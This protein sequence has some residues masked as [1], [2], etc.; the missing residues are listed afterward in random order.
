MESVIGRPA[1]AGGSTRIEVEETSQIG[2]ARRSASAMGH[3]QGLDEEAVGRLAIVTTEA[4]TNI[5]RHGGGGMIV[6]RALCHGGAAIEVLALDKG[7]G[8]LNID[9]AMVDGYSTGGTAGEGLGAMRRLSDVFAVHSQRGV[10]T[11]VLARVGQR[12]HPNIQPPRQAV[13]DDR[14][15]VVCVPMRG[16]MECG[17]R[18]E[19]VAAREG[20]TLMLV[21]GLGHGP[22][23]AAAAACAAQ[24]FH[25][26][27]QRWDDGGL[28]AL[29]AEMRQTRGAAISVVHLDDRASNASF[30][31][32][33]NVEARILGGVSTQHLVPQN[34]IVGHGMPVLRP[35]PA[36]WSV[37]GR[38]VMYT[39][40]IA[41]RWRLDAY[42]HARSIHPALLAGML[43]R[44]FA[45]DRDDVTVIVL[46]HV[47]E[48]SA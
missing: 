11:A 23:A 33:G 12:N 21:D 6:L 28:S 3:A 38:L 43:Y 9:R 15:G 29:D 16:E 13:L 40:G 42:E 44:D 22:E 46:D 18:W 19:L 48:R 17:D 27:A 26:S 25:S 34:G 37:G 20:T 7:S 39:D 4:A 32:V 41:A 1:V 10:G 31:G 14:L 35:M 47:A 2:A 45:R 30:T 8:I 36:T 24:A 5:V